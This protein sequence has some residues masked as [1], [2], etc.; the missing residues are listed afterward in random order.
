MIMSPA[1]SPSSMMTPESDT[2]S[3]LSMSPSIH[4]YDPRAVIRQLLEKYTKED[5]NRLVEEESCVSPSVQGQLPEGGFTGPLFGPD[6]DGIQSRTTHQS[7]GPRPGRSLS[8]N[9]A[10]HRSRRQS[11]AERGSAVVPMAQ[12]LDYACG[13]CAEENIRKTCTR[14]NDLRRHIENFHNSNAMWFC[15]HPGCRMAYDWQTA[16]QNHL[17]TA[18]GRSHMNV[19]EA[20]V[21]LCPQ[22]VFACGF[23]NCTQVFE[24]P[25]EDDTAAT[26]KEYSGH[27]VKHFEEGSNG[28]RWTYSA[29]I[30]NLLRQ[31]QVSA[32]W[33]KA[34]PDMERPQ[35]EWEPQSSMA[36][37]K[38]LEAAH[39]ENL[40]FLIRSIIMLGSSPGD[41]GS[42]EG[43]LE[44]PVRRRCPKAQFQHRLSFE[45]HARSPQLAAERDSMSQFEVSGGIG[46]EYGPYANIQ[47][48][49]HVPRSIELFAN[50]AEQ[51]VGQGQVQFADAAAASLHP[52]TPS[53]L[54]YQGAAESALYG[55]SSSQMMSTALTPHRIAVG[56]DA[57]PVA[58]PTGVFHG[59]HQV[60]GIPGAM[61]VDMNNNGSN[62][63][64]HAAGAVCVSNDRR[65][66][67]MGSYAP[68]G[69]HNSLPADGYDMSSNPVTPEHS[70]MAG[71]YGSPAG[72][73]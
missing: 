38:T 46:V 35:L 54:F 32:F 33:D 60:S 59:I 2:G 25:N 61:D 55:P 40:P 18:H 23:E 39:L 52:L 31:H 45:A 58:S 57:E 34:W 68:M 26:L 27:I 11:T 10:S 70:L 56:Q 47:P 28:G 41:F 4:V 64:A 72:S 44:P 49:Y 1:S 20:K 29:R 9:A 3:P 5:L 22:T 16:Y 51:T 15:Q 19:D 7:Q 24:A 6:R 63:H 37:R 53:Q 67:W 21:R 50:G 13:F 62:A 69:I 30:R 66:N 14:R 42:L 48:G 12:R 73:L 8:S 36:A 71:R 65:G 43:E 17:R